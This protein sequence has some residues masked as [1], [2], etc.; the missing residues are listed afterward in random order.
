MPNNDFFSGEE[1]ENGP[2]KNGPASGSAD[3]GSFDDAF[4]GMQKLDLFDE[5]PSAPETD[6]PGVTQMFEPVGGQPAAPQKNIGEMVFGDIFSAGESGAAQP[7]AVSAPP[8]EIPLE[9]VG[10]PGA[11]EPLVQEITF[12]DEP[13]APAQPA[14]PQAEPVQQAPA[15]QEGHRFPEDPIPKRSPAKPIDWNADVLSRKRAA[16]PVP[17]A[18]VQPAAPAGDP[19]WKQLLD[20]AVKDAP[21]PE[22]A[23][24]VFE[25]VAPAQP[26]AAPVHSAAPAAPAQDALSQL[27]A[28]Q[29][30]Q[31][32]SAVELTGPVLFD[33]DQPDPRFDAP[34]QPQAAPAQPQ[35]APAQRQPAPVQ[36]LSEEGFAPL[37][38][39][40]SQEYGGQSLDGQALGG[41]AFE[42][43]V[44]D[45]PAAGGQP[46]AL[47]DTGFDIG[48]FQAAAEA[49]AGGADDFAAQVAQTSDDIFGN[50]Y[51]ADPDDEDE[52]EVLTS[53]ER[54]R[55]QSGGA[56]SGGG[57]RPPQRPSRGGGRK[58]G[59]GGK[60]SIAIFAWIGLI[61]IALIAIL[62]FAILGGGKDG[63]SAPLPPSSS[64]S[65]SAPAPTP[66]PTPQL[67]AIPRDE[68]YMKLVNKD[69]AMSKEEVD[70]VKTVN[71]DGVPVDERVADAF[72]QL[73]AAG[74]E[75]G[76][77]LKLVAGYRTYD[78]QKASYDGGVSNAAPGTTEHNLGFSADIMSTTEQSYDT[79]KFEATPE[80]KW[81]SENAANYGFI[82]RYPSGKEG[83]TGFDYEPWHYR[84][85]GVEQAQ[86]IKASGLT[87]EEYLAQ[88]NPTGIP[89]EAASSTAEASS[90]TQG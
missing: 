12:D 30:G 84:Y 87:L 27:A 6:A 58:S 75:A 28:P 76:V 10:V 81:L 32:G 80:Y 59:G 67:E 74:K 55:R 41:D 79:A 66:E 17:A 65:T 33:F 34:V 15:A 7:G 1:F 85:V 68:W 70:A 5:E 37:D 20:N 73:L 77:N 36:P 38:G 25:P 61:I 4:A 89:G 52:A 51:D 47:E 24:R 11:P 57:H 56:G 21:H 3:D 42:T 60:K 54:Q 64:A 53:R 23:T 72:E 29:P 69:N 90:G 88:P 26:Q 13:E 45:A 46:G 9:T 50:L 71:V 22:E 14:A 44:F 35:Q 8:V 63:N 49:Q 78:R 31:G 39:F 48:A 16:A 2:V 82:L 83:V 62:L 19:A 40:D 18:S 86:K 43:G